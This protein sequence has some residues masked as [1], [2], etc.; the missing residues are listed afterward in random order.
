[1]PSE[2]EDSIRKPSGLASPTIISLQ[3]S[4]WLVFLCLWLPLCRG[5]GGGP[6]RIPVDS[7]KSLSL[8]QLDGLLPDAMILGAYC[9]G[10]LVAMAMSLVAWFASRQLWNSFFLTQL[11]L[12]FIASVTIVLLGLYHSTDAKNRVENFLST[13]PTLIAYMVWVG[14]AIRRNDLPRAWAR[15]QHAWILAALFIVHIMLLFQGSVLYGYWITIVGQT[16]LFI[17]IEVA[18]YRMQHDLWD[19]TQKV[20]KPQFSILTILGWTAFF[21]LAFSYFQAIGPLVNWLFPASKA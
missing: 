9:N 21:P 11:S 7:L 12:T 2:D 16:C 1:M 19:T 3:F 15:L 5:C 8:S 14:L 13:V 17:S 20:V 6:D 18:V 4:G 10:L